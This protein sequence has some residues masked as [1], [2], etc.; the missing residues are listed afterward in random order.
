MQ[1]V[2]PLFFNLLETKR[3]TLDRNF[4]RVLFLFFFLLFSFFSNYTFGALPSC[5][6]SPFYNTLIP[7]P[8]N[9]C[10]VQGDYDDISTL[11]S[12]S[13]TSIKTGDGSAGENLYVHDMILENIT[14]K[15]LDKPSCETLNQKAI[16]GQNCMGY[17]PYCGD[18]KNVNGNYIYVGVTEGG[19]CNELP[20][21][22]DQEA[23]QKKNICDKINEALSNDDIDPDGNFNYNNC[24]YGDIEIVKDIDDNPVLDDE[25]NIVINFGLICEE[26]YSEISNRGNCLGYVGEYIDP[27]PNNNCELKSCVHLTEKELYDSNGYIYIGSSET[28]VEN[29]GGD[30][31]CMNACAQN[32]EMRRRTNNKYCDPYIYKVVNGKFT[33]TPDDDKL[34]CNFIKFNR[35]RYIRGGSGDTTQ[36]FYHYCPITENDSITCP[37]DIEKVNDVFH[38][39]MRSG[40]YEAEYKSF[41]TTYS[42]TGGVD[43]DLGRA[44]VLRVCSTRRTKE[45]VLCGASTTP[46]PECDKC[47]GIDNNAITD[48]NNPNCEKYSAL[49]QNTCESNYCI[50]TTDCAFSPDDDLCTL[51]TSEEYGGTTGS[52]SDTY[53]SWFYRPTPINTNYNSFD[54]QRMCTTESQYFANYPDCDAFVFTVIFYTHFERCSNAGCYVPPGFNCYGHYLAW[55]PDMSSPPLCGESK[56]SGASIRAL[57]RGGICRNRTIYDEPDMNK[58]AYLAGDLQTSY[59]DESGGPIT[60]PSEA[61]YKVQTYVRYHNT[62]ELEACGERDCRV[63]CI[64]GSCDLQYC[65]YD[66]GKVLETN[67]AMDCD[68]EDDEGDSKCIGYP[69]TGWGPEDKLVRT[70][71]KVMGDKVCV[72]LDMNSQGTVSAANLYSNARRESGAGYLDLYSLLDDNSRESTSCG[73]TGAAKCS[74]KINSEVFGENLF[75]TLGCPSTPEDF[76]DNVLNGGAVIID[77]KE[78]TLRGQGLSDN[79]I[80]VE[81]ETL[82]LELRK[83]RELSINNDKEDF[84]EGDTVFGFKEATWYPIDLIQY[85]GNNQP[86]GFPRGYYDANEVFYP[87]QQCMKI[88]LA[89]GPPRFYKY[90]TME[91]TPKLFTPILYIDGVVRNCM[92]IISGKNECETAEIGNIEDTLATFIDPGIVVKFGSSK[93]ITFAPF[94][95]LREPVD[96]DGDSAYKMIDSLDNTKSKTAY[97][98]EKIYENDNAKICLKELGY[99]KTGTIDVRMGCI[100]RRKPGKNNIIVLPG[101]GSEYDNGKLQAVL[102]RGSISPDTCSS[103]NYGDKCIELEEDSEDINGVK[104]ARVIS[105]MNDTEEFYQDISVGNVGLGDG[106]LLNIGYSNSN[107]SQLFNE[108][109][110]NKINLFNEKI[111]ENPDAIRLSV[112]QEFENRCKNDI[113]IRCNFF[114]SEK[115]AYGYY[116]EACINEGFDQ[117]LDEVISYD[118][119]ITGPMGKCVLNDE[120]RTNPECRL[121]VYNENYENICDCS[122]DNCKT[123]PSVCY[124]GGFNGNSISYTKAEGLEENEYIQAHICK[125]VR[126]GDQLP[127]G[128]RDFNTEMKQGHDSEGNLLIGRRETR[129]EAGL[130]VDIPVK[131]SCDEISYGINNDSSDSDFSD[132]R[133]NYRGLFW[134]SDAGKPVNEVHESHIRRTRQ[135]QEIYPIDVPKID[136]TSDDYIKDFGYADF[137]TAI[138]GMI[139]P[140]LDGIPGF[141]N[142][143]WKEKEGPDNVPI[144]KCEPTG[145]ADNKGE[146]TD[147]RNSCERYKCPEIM[148]KEN[149]ESKEYKPEYLA[150]TNYESDETKGKY[151]GYA[152]WPEF[153]IN[154]ID[155]YMKDNDGDGVIEGDK[156]SDGYPDID[157]LH[158]IKADRCIDGYGPY[159][160]NYR[161]KEY[162]DDISDIGNLENTLYDLP[163]IV[164]SGSI[165]YLNKTVNELSDN[166]DILIGYNEIENSS[167]SINVGNEPLNLANTRLPKRYCNQI[168]AWEIVLNKDGIGNFDS[169]DNFPDPHN[170]NYKCLDSN[171]RET[172]CIS[173]A[174]EGYE[175]A[176]NRFC[177][178][179]YC[180]AKGV[181][182]I[183]DDMN[184]D[185]RRNFWERTGGATWERTNASRFRADLGERIY[186]TCDIGRNYYPRNTHFLDDV[187]DQQ[188]VLQ[189]S[190]GEDPYVNSCELERDLYD[191]FIVDLGNN[192]K[193]TYISGSTGQ[194]ISNPRSGL[195]NPIKQFIANKRNGINSK[196]DANFDYPDLLVVDGSEQTSPSR[197][198][199]YLGLWSPII[200]PCVRS[201]PYTGKGLKNTEGNGPDT[202]TGG[203]RWRKVLSTEEKSKAGEVLNL[204]KDYKCTKNT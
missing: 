202:Y 152:E 69:A 133:G 68:V 197:Y 147:L 65:G 134:E 150:G 35:L 14:C 195:P 56:H 84:S 91:S 155:T 23:L 77:R 16:P 82:R 203:A 143:F 137:P 185:A 4:Y 100:N 120:S 176:Q 78:T 70:R 39:K 66:Q 171:L 12:C 105:E 190:N 74:K 46:V 95:N 118:Y 173:S 5:S 89:V 170:I 204:Y 92:S 109:I 138:E 119:G 72:F 163:A 194:Y 85:I 169:Y 20:Y 43:I 8:G 67:R 111:K 156:D 3:S 168:G 104:I 165:D 93:H 87:E 37:S 25:G 135:I 198:C 114:K 55:D 79:Q 145:N 128:V 90:V 64:F 139:D 80:E 175:N 86:S 19:N 26:Y 22:H 160:T 40:S 179:L 94:G 75:S 182:D 27:D 24:L 48:L 148:S 180:P 81:L 38:L 110:T 50:K 127:A 151:H 42:D 146:Y 167:L 157:D 161:L 36:C 49:A 122:G 187:G 200:L 116:H 129:R 172:K 201:C 6:S 57:G 10:G 196:P 7:D 61:T 54:T 144:A 132:K 184:D 18:L 106:Y 99:T 51:T 121:V 124:S 45:Y 158:I 123:L 30:S 140:D 44:C 166:A 136:S 76:E 97:F 62:L 58:A 29:C 32:N 131:A 101:V 96:E 53:N 33:K 142:G 126:V 117:I 31:A 186:G 177:E 47:T 159:G 174:T 102:T 2:M 88:P 83:C 154:T 141:C 52:I 98:L 107:C 15:L 191:Q 130:C 193:T 164:T 73:D 59:T 63:D 192:I 189:C 162:M 188:R 199:N 125:C 11:R 34:R 112:Y 71:A 108:C 17:L 41:T 13:D 149:E 113:E 21:C 183:E 115:N 103:S 178:R 153:D 9:D 181:E 28:C 60:T 1:I